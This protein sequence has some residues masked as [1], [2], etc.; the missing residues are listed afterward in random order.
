MSIDRDEV[1]RVAELARLVLPEA[2]VERAAAQLSEIL[3]FVETLRQL[4]LADCEPSTFASTETA[5]RE[6]EVDGRRLSTADALR[7]TP[8]A[9]TGYFLVPPIVEDVNP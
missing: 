4:D 6:D 8:A 5:L 9:E 2:S 1:R 3:A 7:A